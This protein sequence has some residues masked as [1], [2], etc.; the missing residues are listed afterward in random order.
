MKSRFLLVI[1]VLALLPLAFAFAQ[2]EEEEALGSFAD[3]EVTEEEVAAAVEALGEDGFVG[4][5]A[6]TFGTDYHFKVADSAQA[7]ADELGIRAEIFD[8]QINV[9]RQISGIESFVANG[10]S[11]LVVCLF[12][13]PSIQDALQAAAD[14]GVQIVQY[15]GR[16]MADLG[17]V[18]ISIED[19]D[20]GFAAGEYAAQL[21]NDELEGRANVAILDYPDVANVVVRADAIRAA[22]EEFA[23]DA[24]IVGNYLGGTTEFGL[25]SMES[26]L[27]EHPEINVV[28]SINDAGAYG[29]MQAIENAGRDDA[30]IVGIDAE[31]QAMEFIAEGGMYRG[32]IDTSPALTGVNSLNAAVKLLAGTEIPQN[33]AVTVTLV[34]ADNVEEM[35]AGSRR[36]GSRSD[37]GL[38][39]RRFAAS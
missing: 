8:S 19:A 23:P 11:V 30:I 5:V 21:I 9:E 12:D 35:L 6:C 39:G 4:I 13:P 34:N 20:L 22:L 32:T 14:A 33:I 29:A 26:A 31:P 1:L 27:V 24:V 2:D 37:P 16:Q 7:R 18:T 38:V 36:G 25:A 17:G 15:A 28:V 3:L 10:V